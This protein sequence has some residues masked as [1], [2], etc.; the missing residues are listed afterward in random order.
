[1]GE[2]FILIASSP[3]KIKWS[4]YLHDVL[5]LGMAA[6]ALRLVKLRIP[7][8]C[9]TW[10]LND[11]GDRVFGTRVMSSSRRWSSELLELEFCMSIR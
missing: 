3:T 11:V 8:L 10:E 7:S 5:L 4:N 6:S 9:E 1:M 2:K